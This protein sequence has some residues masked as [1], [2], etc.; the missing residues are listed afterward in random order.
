MTGAVE[1]RIHLFP[2]NAGF[3]RPSTALAKPDRASQKAS[4][5]RFQSTSITSNFVGC[6]SSIVVCW[7]RCARR[8]GLGSN[9][10]R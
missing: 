2:S 4:V 6:L 7:P 1:H 9:T 5:Y 8:A 10:M 3:A